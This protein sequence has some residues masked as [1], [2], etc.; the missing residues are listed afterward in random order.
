M[1]KRKER[2][3]QKGS[4]T[5]RQGRIKIKEIKYVWRVHN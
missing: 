4:A 2:R 3:R 1:Q 5:I